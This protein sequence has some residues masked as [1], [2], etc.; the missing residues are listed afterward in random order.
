MPGMIGAS[1][2]SA[3]AFVDEMEVGVGVVEI[4]GDGRVGAG[5][6]L[7]REGV[8]VVLG[9]ARLRVP[10][11]IGG[12]FDAEPVAGLGADEFDQ[13]VGVAEFAGLG[14]ARGQVAAQGDGAPDAGGLVLAEDLADALARRAD[15]RKVR[16]GVETFGGDFLDDREGPFAG[17]TAG[18][19]GDRE[20]GGLE[21]CQPG[22]GGAQLVDAFGRLR[23]EEFDGDFG[24]HLFNQMKNSR[25]PSPPWIGLSSQPLTVRPSAPRIVAVLSRLRRRA[26][27]CGRCRPCRRCPG[28]LRTAA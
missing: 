15:A 6:D 10:F 5:L 12:N 27:H 26:R 11:G 18:P 22:A 7:A 14:H 1:M 24:F 23:G 13:F 3:R 25:L 9:A 21:F 16:C 17:R 4:L 19:V 2:P 8:E 28:R 20:E